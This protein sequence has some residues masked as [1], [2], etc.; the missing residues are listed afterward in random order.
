[1]RALVLLLL[2]SCARDDMSMSAPALTNADAGPIRSIQLPHDEPELPPG[3]G[4]DA[5]VAGCV[6]CHSPR[7]VTNQPVF[8]RTTWTEEVNKMGKTFGAPI[9]A[10]RV[11]EIVD[12]LVMFHGKED[13]K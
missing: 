2:A 4:R 9:P 13:A 6:T 10:D 1:M 7:Y 12:Y 8:S 5:F 11:P 3:R